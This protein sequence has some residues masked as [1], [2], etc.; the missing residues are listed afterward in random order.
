FRVSGDSGT[1]WTAAVGG[2]G[3]AGETL[4][5]LVIGGG[6]G[7]SASGSSG[8]PAAGVA[9]GPLVPGSNPC[10][11]ADG[12]VGICV[13]ACCSMNDRASSNEPLKT[14]G[15]SRGGRCPNA[16]VVSLSDSSAI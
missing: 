11:A 2:F 16:S 14:T 9:L 8:E 10:I 13:P 1:V 6:S 5:D 15:G 7:F 12:A 3:V 4:S